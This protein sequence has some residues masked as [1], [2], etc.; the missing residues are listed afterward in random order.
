MLVGK[1]RGTSVS[2][3]KSD[4]IPPESQDGIARVYGD[5]F[6]RNIGTSDAIL[7]MY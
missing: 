5:V 1:S 4:S 6:D 7:N 3:K 2:R